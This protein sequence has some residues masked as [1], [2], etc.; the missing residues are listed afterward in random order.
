VWHGEVDD[1]DPVWIDGDGL[2]HRGGRWVALPEVEW[3]LMAVLVD[4][5]GRPVSRADLAVAGWDS[6][7]DLGPR[8][9]HRI[10]KARRRVAPLGLRITGIRGR[11]Y[12]LSVEP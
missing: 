1:R 3:R 12:H 9:T 8:L 6:D 4:R 10:A 11:G 2:L 7:S 5:I